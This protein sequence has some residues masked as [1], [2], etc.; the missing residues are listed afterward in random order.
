M[1][2]S[3]ANVQSRVRL[4]ASARGIYTWR[5]NVG[6]LKDI[7]GRPVRYGLAN[8][9]PALNKVLKSADVIGIE[10]VVITQ[11]MVGQTIGRFYSR[12]CKAEGWKRDNSERT[13]AQEAWRDLINRLGGNAKIVDG[14]V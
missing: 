4:E 10:P 7:T 3:E 11:D 14:P 2:N 8:D 9:S 1:K 13:K 6:V 5:N 12:E